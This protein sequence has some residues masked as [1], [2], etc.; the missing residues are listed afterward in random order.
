MPKK[1]G[2]QAVTLNTTR[3]LYRERCRQYNKWLNQEIT[4]DEL[5]TAGQ[6]IKDAAAE[7][8]NLELEDAGETVRGTVVLELQ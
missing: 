3:R 8:R 6:Y 2:N 5:R 1:P 7:V 4:C